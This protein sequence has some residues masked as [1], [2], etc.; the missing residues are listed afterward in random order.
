VS[1]TRR[2][3]SRGGR[4]RSTRDFW[5]NDELVGVD[6]T[7]LPKIRRSEHPTALVDSLGP[8]PF[9]GGQVAPHYFELLYDRAA[10]LA[11]AL[12]ASAGL[13]APEDEFE[14]DDGRAQDTQASASGS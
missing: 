7:T 1:P 12:A 10:S 2:R 5:G 6:E 11:I 9:P 4:R 8:L 13:D 3:S 14:D